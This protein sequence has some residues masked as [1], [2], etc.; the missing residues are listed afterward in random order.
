MNCLTQAWN[1][2][3]SELRAWLRH[4]LNNAP[5]ADDLLQDTFVKAL[6]Q[7]ER[8]CDLVNPRAWLFEVA[9]NALIDHWRTSR[10]TMELPQDMTAP[11]DDPQAIDLLT[12][13]LPRVL[14]ELSAEDREAITLCDLQGMPQSDYANLKGLKLSAAKSRL[15]RA[16][17]RLGT[18][19]ST[20]C[21]VQH[22]D[23]GSVSTFVQRPPL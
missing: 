12:A 18:R 15:Q 22:D 10:D 2:H 3:E 6:H 20:A 21:K 14:S 16:R 19:L 23:N 13:C 4:R 8:F 1:Q 17:K 9:R 7:R 5:E 11:T